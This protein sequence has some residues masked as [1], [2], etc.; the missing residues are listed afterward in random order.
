MPATLHWT[1]DGGLAW[2]LA[3]GADANITFLPSARYS[4]AANVPRIADPTPEIFSP[5]WLNTATPVR[6]LRGMALET[7]IIRVCGRA[8]HSVVP[9]AELGGR[10][11][12]PICLPGGFCALANVSNYAGAPLA[13][14]LSIPKEA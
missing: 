14:A 8:P 6:D 7:T 9:I 2:R 10:R 5:M 13:T 3:E 11:L 12:Q 1:P 4:T